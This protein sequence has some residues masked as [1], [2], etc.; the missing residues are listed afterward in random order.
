[1]IKIDRDRV[2]HLM[3]YRSIPN[4]ISLSY[5]TGVDHSHI[6]KVLKGSKQM[7]IMTLDKVCTALRCQ[8]GELIVH[9]INE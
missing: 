8:P 3:S 5:L 2:E 1:M 9:H 7:G 4:K 6:C